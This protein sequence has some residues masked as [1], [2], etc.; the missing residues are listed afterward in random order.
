ME[1]TQERNI[2]ALYTVHSLYLTKR[3]QN[4]ALTLY[5]QPYN[6]S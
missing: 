4:Y 6:I 2:H 3:L 5:K 1:Q